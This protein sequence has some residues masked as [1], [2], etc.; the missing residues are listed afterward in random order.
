[1]IGLAENPDFDQIW[2]MGHIM[3]AVKVEDYKLLE[4]I[5]EFSNTAGHKVNIQNYIVFLRNNKQTGNKKFKR[6]PLIFAVLKIK[7]LE[8]SLKETK[9]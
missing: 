8:A 6:M 5:N 2:L 1:M 7:Y 3:L 9:I 4:L